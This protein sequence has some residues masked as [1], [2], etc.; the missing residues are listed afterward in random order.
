MI[1][2]IAR[3]ICPAARWQPHYRRP[4]NNSV[5]LNPA[6]IVPPNCFSI[7]VEPLGMVPSD[8]S[9]DKQGDACSTCWANQWKSDGNGKACK[10]HKVLA[11]MAP[12]A[13]P[14]DPLMIL[15]VSATGLKSFDA[16]VASVARVFER[17]PYGVI[18]TITCDQNTDYQTLRFGN[19]QPLP[20]ADRKSTRL[21]S[22][23]IPLSR[24]PSS[25]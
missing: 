15:R 13:S 22:S 21:N 19:P 2:M 10:N 3:S 20:E 5:Y 24:M 7:G 6:N 14:E 16:H 18:T 1:Q 23:H 17:P 12:N 11:V 4:L 25:A 8:N 9:P